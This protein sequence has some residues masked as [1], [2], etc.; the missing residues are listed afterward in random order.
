ML[1]KTEKAMDV[2]KYISEPS[3]LQIK[4]IA[5]DLECSE[6]QVWRALKRLRKNSEIVETDVIKA[7]ELTTVLKKYYELI[8]K[9]YRPLKKLTLKEFELVEEVEGAIYGA[10]E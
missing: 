5:S 4:A 9:K 6:R 10:P 7:S 3:T 2:L 1:T 8:S